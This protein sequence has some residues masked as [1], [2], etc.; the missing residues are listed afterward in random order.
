MSNCPDESYKF[1][2]TTR[3]VLQVRS[4]SRGKVVSAVDAVTRQRLF[5]RLSLTDMVDMRSFLDAPKRP[6]TTIKGSGEVSYH[7]HK[8]NHRKEVVE[9][10]TEL[11]SQVYNCE[12]FFIFVWFSI[13]A[14]IQFLLPFLY[15]IQFC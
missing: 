7:I 6:G 3:C 2:H 1:N 12:C 10:G 11:H 9:L 15:T 5:E 4:Y 8:R 13:C 14:Y